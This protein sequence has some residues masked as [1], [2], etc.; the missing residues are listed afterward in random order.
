MQKPVLV[1]VDYQKAFDD[2]SFFGRR[3]NLD[4]EKNAGEVL[5]AFRT[6]DLPVIHIR[7]DSVSRGSPL[8]ADQPGNAAMDFATPRSSEPVLSKTVNSA[9]IGTDLE[10]RLRALNADPVVIMGISTD[11]CVSTTTRMSANLGFNTILVGDACFT[12]NRKTI[13]ADT[14]HE[15]ELAILD[16]EFAEVTTSKALIGRLA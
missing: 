13:A 3:N 7:H 15:T 4:A 1:I 6:R 10:N 14:V 9:F 2:A 5:E 8:G 12:F 16:G 11:H